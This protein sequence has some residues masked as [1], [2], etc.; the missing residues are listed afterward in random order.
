MT[1]INLMLSHRIASLWPEPDR[2]DPM[3]FIPEAERERNR[4]AYVPFGAGIH[5]CLGMHFSQQQ[6]KMLIT[7]L[8]LNANLRAKRREPPR[9]YHWP[10]CRPRKPLC[11][12]VD[13]RCPQS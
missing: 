9:W 2:F 3:R 5:K 10:S 12:A 1:G 13:R 7:H 8:L 4:F 11:V 6:A